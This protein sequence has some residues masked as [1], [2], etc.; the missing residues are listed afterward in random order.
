M[1]DIIKHECG[2][3]LLRLR[4]PLS[5]YQEKYGSA[6]YGL[7]KLQQMMQKLVNRGQD[8]AGVATIKL[9][10]EAGKRYISRHRSNEEQSLKKVYEYIFNRFED[11]DPALLN[12]PEW[13]KENH[14]FMGE[15]LMGHL[16]YGTHGENHIENC[17]P[18]FRRNNWQSKSLLVAGNFNLTNVDEMF[19]RLVELGQHPKEKSDTVTVLERIGHF[20]EEEWHRLYQ[21]YKPEF[22]TRQEVTQKIIQEIDLA[23]VLRQSVRRF[24]GGYVMGGMVGHGDAFILRD[25]N[26]I[27]PAYYYVDDEIIVAASERPAI[28][29]A[30]DLHVDK[31]KEL[32]RANALIIKKDGS[33]KLEEIQEP[34]QSTPCSFERIYFSRA[35]DRDIYKE[36]QELGI[37]LVKPVLESVKYNFNKTVFSYIPNS[38]EV[39]FLGL[40]KGLEKEA[41]RIKKE[42]ILA[43]GEKLNKEN[44]SKIMRI[45]P[46]VEKMVDKHIKQRTFITADA[47][48]DKLVSHVY[49]ITYGVV[50]NY[51]D[52]LVLVDDSIVRGTT[53][54]ASIIKLIS[55]LKPKKIIILSSAPQIRFPDC[56]GIDM[57][58]MKDFV[59]FNA[60]IQLL[61]ENGKQGLI[62]S[63]YEKAKLELTKPK[64]EI[65]NVVKELYEAFPYEEVSAKIC[66]IVKPD[67]LEIELEVIYQT[68]EDLNATC[69][70]YGDWYFTG[71]YPTHGGNKVA[72]QAFVNY[73][74]N[75]HERAY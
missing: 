21:Y 75:N 19:D 51:K 61:K 16:R 32:P 68:V 69:P 55:R 3:V 30:F 60:I 18:V 53:L 44:L 29:I 59:A 63:V 43:L 40:V 26:G 8:G 15:V 10:T 12:D 41:K 65:Q 70:G 31:I 25:P 45:Q 72:N 6:F 14:A 28:Q 13:L 71:N 5:F 67:G 17:H 1:S 64:H 34:Q 58:K 11:V 66:E 49:D 9:D 47:N 7:N 24:D 54:K 62:D 4:K 37:R 2:V 33:Y 36:R 48:R 50:R 22:E 52:T 39:A 74:E 27:R 23:R 20:L 73:I 42:R 56:Y 57:S 38:S 35:N 46:R